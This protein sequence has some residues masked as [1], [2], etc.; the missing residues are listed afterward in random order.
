MFM[1]SA[2]FNTDSD[3]A[4]TTDEEATMSEGNV[5]TTDEGEAGEERQDPEERFVGTIFFMGKKFIFS[6]FFFNG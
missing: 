4:D 2:L 3:E 1:L 6:K 5:D